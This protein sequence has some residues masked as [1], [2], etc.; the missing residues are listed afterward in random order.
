M[1]HR[2]RREKVKRDAC[3]SLVAEPM[4]VVY[5]LQDSYSLQYILSLP[6]ADASNLLADPAVADWVATLSIPQIQAVAAAA[7]SAPL[8]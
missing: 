7:K 3:T 4:L 8:S 2:G 6:G 1:I 5:C